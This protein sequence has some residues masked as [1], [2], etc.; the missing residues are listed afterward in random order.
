MGLRASG[1][2]KTKKGVYEVSM[3][4]VEFKEDDHFIVFAPSLDL[5]GY[6]KSAQ[7]AKESYLEALDEFMRYTANKG[8]LD[9]ALTE[10]GWQ[11]KSKKSIKTYIPPNHSKL[12]D[13]NPT[14]HEIID[15]KEYKVSR[16]NLEL[17]Y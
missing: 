6:G 1:K 12:I 5:S 13:Q 14:Y 8:S 10:L 7:E 11:L 9:K 16:E 4:L 3:P 15:N 17:A 2:L